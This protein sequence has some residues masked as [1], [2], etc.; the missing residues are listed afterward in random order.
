MSSLL[1]VSSSRF[2]LTLF[3]FVAATGVARAQFE[4]SIQLNRETYLT[5]EGVDAT[6][7]VTNRSGGDV[8]MGG[9]NGT[10][11]LSFEITD[12]QGRSLPPMNF[13]TEEQL[14]FKAGTTMSRKVSLGENF[15]FGDPGTYGIVANVYHPISQ[16][17]YASP[18]VK[19][20]FMDAHPFIKKV[21]GVPMG[22]SGAGQIRRYELCLL[23]NLDRMQLY[24]RVVQDKT[25]MVLTTISLGNCIM[26]TDPQ[27]GLDKENRLHLLYMAAPHVYAHIGLDAQGQVFKRL[28]FREFESNRPQLAVQTDQTIGVNGGQPYDP[29]AESVGPVRPAGRSVKQRPPGL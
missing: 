14:V 10:A 22:Q 24:V 5:H 2:L 19:A 17:Y 28:Y 8:V 12:P 25:D 27:V 15:S 26:V 20:N 1:P 4:T 6:V 29:T 9:P 3:L 13:R 21:F 23:R 11:W 7:V 16:Q 18:R